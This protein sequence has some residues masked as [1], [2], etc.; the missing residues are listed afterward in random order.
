MA[1]DEKIREARELLDWAISHLNGSIK[2]K[3]L[4]TNIKTIGFRFLQ[5]IIN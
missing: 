5:R 4:I 2:S 1:N 3:S